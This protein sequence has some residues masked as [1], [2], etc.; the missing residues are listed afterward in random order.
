MIL[1]PISLKKRSLLL[2]LRLCNNSIH[3]KRSIRSFSVEVSQDEK[4]ER[5]TPHEHVL[6]RPGMYLGQI[7]PSVV[8][9]WVINDKLNIME[10]KPLRYSPALAKIFDEILVNAA[11]NRFLSVF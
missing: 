10:K 8:E 11:D 4:Y 2:Q 1:S 5:K 6:L 3:D 7:E 9:T